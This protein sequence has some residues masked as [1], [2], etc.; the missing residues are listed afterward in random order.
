MRVVGIAL[1]IVI[2]LLMLY[3]VFS[4]SGILSNVRVYINTLVVWLT[5]TD[6][7][8]YAPSCS[9]SNRYAKCNANGT[10]TVSVKSRN[11]LIVSAVYPSTCSVSVSCSYA[12][13]KKYGSDIVEFYPIYKPS[14]YWRANVSA[15]YGVVAFTFTCS[16]SPYDI[17]VVV[18]AR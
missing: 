3:T 7:T 8:I 17:Y 12:V 9:V 1:I 2:L 13:C 18:N 6:Y 5:P 4:V 11:D 15:V 16:P 14:P 10:V